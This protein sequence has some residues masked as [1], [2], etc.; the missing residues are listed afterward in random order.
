MIRKEASEGSSILQ[1]NFTMLQGF[2]KPKIYLKLLPH[3]HA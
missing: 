3:S 2:V 1:V